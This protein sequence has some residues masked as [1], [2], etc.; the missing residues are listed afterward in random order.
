METLAN[1]VVND[2]GVNYSELDEIYV[3]HPPNSFAIRNIP[4]CYLMMLCYSYLIPKK[5]TRDK[6]CLIWLKPEFETTTEEGGN[7]EPSW[8]SKQSSANQMLLYQP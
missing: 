3:I 8:I 1:S 6:L 5:Y 2:V 7:I 4:D